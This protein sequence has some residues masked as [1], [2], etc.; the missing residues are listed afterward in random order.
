MEKMGLVLEG[1]GMRGVY[2]AGVLDFFLDHDLEF[3]SCYGVSAGSVNACSYLSK[4]RGRAFSVDVDYL[5][6][7]RYASFNNLLKTGNFFGTEMCYETIPN[8]LNPFDYDTFKEY[9]GD[10][11]AVITDCECGHPEYI[12]ITD[13]AK[14]IDY[15]RASCSLPL[16]AEIVEINGKKYLDGGITDSIPIRK[17]VKDGNMK[18]VVILTRDVS[19]RKAPTELLSVIRVKY[20]KYPNMIKAIENRYKMYN[21]TLDYIKNQEEKGNVFVIRP[22]KPVTIGRLEKNKKKLTSLYKAGYRDA[23]AKYEDLKNFLL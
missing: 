21:M 8:K 7:K 6:D 14:Q 23:K 17:S 3:S 4:Q 9:K 13:L 12:K 22:S 1:G 16:M 10:F 19:Y 15:I 20:K 5:E 18:N 2:T 11:Y